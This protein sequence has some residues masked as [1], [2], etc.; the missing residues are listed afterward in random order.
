MGPQAER[1]PVSVIVS[2]LLLPIFA[3]IWGTVTMIKALLGIE[4]EEIDVI[5]EEDPE[6]E[7]DDYDD[8]DAGDDGDT[9][10]RPYTR[11]EAA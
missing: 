10:P 2:L 4:D 9:E 5:D 3:V 7:L 11:G 1:S 6:L 8:P